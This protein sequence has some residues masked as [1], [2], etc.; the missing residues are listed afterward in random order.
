MSNKKIFIAI[1]AFQEKDL[2]NTIQSAF[3]NAEQPNDVYIGICN[4]RLDNTFEDFSS[5]PNVRVANIQTP[6]GFGLGIGFLLATWLLQDEHYVMRVDGHMRFKKNWDKILKYYHDL[7]SQTYCYDV[8]ISSRTSFFTKDK[9]KDILHNYDRI[10][11]YAIKRENIEAVS[12]VKG[13]VKEKY[14]PD[15]WDD[16]DYVQIHFVS[17]H[18]MFGTNNLFK[19]IIPDPRIHMFGEE[20]LIGLRAWT[21]DFRMFA[22]KEDVV[23]H[24]DKTKEYLD[25]SGIDDWRNSLNKQSSAAI[26][27]HYRKYYFNILL[28]KEFGALAAK[29]E[30]SYLEYMIEMGYNY[31]DII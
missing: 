2:L 25:E 26:I 6:Y 21:N 12:K 4:Q 30:E 20:H 22:I 5:F 16:K 31:R 14:V 24:L 11:P 10:D 29:D 9:E 3:E 7:I 18:F 8:I 19:K 13:I 17:G 28:G 27:N 1:P 15:L 23:Y